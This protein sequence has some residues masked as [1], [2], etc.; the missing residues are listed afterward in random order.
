MYTANSVRSLPTSERTVPDKAYQGRGR[1]SFKNPPVHDVR[2]VRASRVSGDYCGSFLVMY[3]GQ[4]KQ[5][6]ERTRKKS[7]AS[8]ILSLFSSPLYGFPLRPRGIFCFLCETIRAKSYD[9]NLP[10]VATAIGKGSYTKSLIR[11]TWERSS[12]Y[13]NP[14]PLLCPLI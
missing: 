5:C 1:T 7:L 13:F 4:T 2:N 8:R 10:S 11:E 6:S 12:S 3:Q 14:G 9:L